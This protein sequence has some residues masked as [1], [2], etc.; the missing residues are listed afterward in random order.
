MIREGALENPAPDAIFAL[1]VDLAP[2]GRIGWASGTIL[3]A[4]DKL[5]IIVRGKQTHGAMPWAGVDPIVVASQI[6]LGL[7]TV[8]SRQTNVVKSPAVIS[9]GRIQGGVN[10]STI[11]EFVEM[12]GT[13]R[14]LDPAMREDLHYQIQQKTTSIARSAGATANVMISPVLP[15]TYNDPDLTGRMVAIL[16]RVAGK[17]HVSL[18]PPAMGGEDFS[19]YLNKIPGMFF[20]LGVTPE[21]ADPREIAPVHSPFFH[22]DERALLFGVRSLVHLAVDFLTQKE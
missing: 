9:I 16:E 11:P 21:D 13:I 15:I 14:T 7:Q 1:H 10:G 17:D 4:V 2:A 20:F 22:I 18:L 8:I 3:A 12:E 19:F 5:K 6:V